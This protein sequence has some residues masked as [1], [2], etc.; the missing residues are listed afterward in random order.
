MLCSRC[1]K[2][3]AIFF[4]SIG[5]NS[6][7][8]EGLCGPCAQQIG[9]GPIKDIMSKMGV[10]EQEFLDMQEQ[11][12]EA[13]KDD[14]NYTGKEN[15]NYESNSGFPAIK[16]LFSNILFPDKDFES[17]EKNNNENNKH[18]KKAKRRNLDLYCNNLTQKA[19]NGKLD[20]IIGR[21]KEINRVIT[22]RS[23]SSL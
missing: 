11:V 13:L 6:K 2:R 19:K 20:R 22:G 4:I 10:S 16:N 1:K 8:P 3:S 21:E 23:L 9:A 7:A 17:T 14:I 18:T 12:S 15:E 5:E